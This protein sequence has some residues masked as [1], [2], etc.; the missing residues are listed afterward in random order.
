MSTTAA[1]PLSP[2]TVAR[3]F[4]RRYYTVLSQSP[5]D[6]F[7]FY[8]NNAVFV[9]DGADSLYN[10]ESIYAEGKDAICKIMLHGALNYRNCFTKINNIDT[11]IT[12][13]DGL[14]VQVMGEISSDGQAMRPFSQTIVLTKQSSMRYNV[15]N[16]IFRYQDLLPASTRPTARLEFGDNEVNITMI[17]N[18]SDRLVTV[19]DE[20]M[21][22]VTKI[23]EELLENDALVSND[24]KI[25]DITPVDESIN[26]SKENEE[27]NVFSDA[28]AVDEGIIDLTYDSES[29]CASNE[30]NMIDNNDFMSI[31]FPEHSTNESSEPID[32]VSVEKVSFID[33][34][35]EEYEHVIVNAEEAELLTSN[36]A[37]NDTAVKSMEEDPSSTPQDEKLEDDADIKI[38][39]YADYL[40]CKDKQILL[41]PTDLQGNLVSGSTFLSDWVKVNGN[42][43]IGKPSPKSTKEPL[44]QRERP[45]FANKLTFTKTEY[46][47]TA[48]QNTTQDPLQVFIGNICHDA[49]EDNLRKIFERYGKITRFRIHTNPNRL[50]VPNYA[51]VTYETPEAVQNCLKDKDSIFFPENSDQKLNVNAE[52][53]PSQ[54]QNRSSFQRNVINRNNNREKIVASKAREMVFTNT[55]SRNGDNNNSEI[56]KAPKKNEKRNSISMGRRASFR[57]PQ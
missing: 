12:L 28:P 39:T 5:N 43:L 36:D 44:R 51:F 2:N 23:K 29:S 21:P 24:G 10:D 47:N 4:V 27:Y 22:N 52:D 53:P 56:K 46:T 11:N 26:V 14:L 16:D 49:S 48:N 13:N 1:R 41:E 30:L 57:E 42:E 35:H 45:Y 17:T 15:Q 38:L 7:R 19:C 8:C 18:T 31:Q 55:M 6:L 40:K 54:R 32:D 33:S 50:W 3:E 20:T 25:C 37:G 9:H 34:G